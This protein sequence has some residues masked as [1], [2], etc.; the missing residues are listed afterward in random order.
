MEFSIPKKPEFSK[1]ISSWLS[2]ESHTQKKKNY[3][4]FNFG[5]FGRFQNAIIKLN[6]RIKIKQHF[7]YTYK[8]DSL[9]FN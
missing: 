4:D 1:K 5:N 6:L 2:F 7:A 8:F 9:H 3:T